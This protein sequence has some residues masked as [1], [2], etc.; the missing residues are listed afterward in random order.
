MHRLF[1]LV[2]AVVVLAV[3]YLSNLKNAYSSIV[4]VVVVE[5][6]VI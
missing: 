2:L 4:A 3:I 1:V 5:M 6:S